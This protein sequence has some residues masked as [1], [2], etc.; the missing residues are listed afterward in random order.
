[1][2]LLA[3]I[4]CGCVIASTLTPARASSLRSLARACARSAFD[5]ACIPAVPDPALAAGVAVSLLPGLDAPLDWAKVAPLKASAENRT[6]AET[7]CRFFGFMN[8]SFVAPGR[9]PDRNP[10]RRNGRTRCGDSR[11]AS[12]TRSWNVLPQNAVKARSRFRRSVE[13]IAPD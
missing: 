13:T 11:R 3:R 5:D 12:V 10:A 6:L 9:A 8:F 2:I 4:A 7:R 1:M